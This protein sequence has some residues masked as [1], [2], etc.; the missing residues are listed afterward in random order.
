[1]AAP[2][3]YADADPQ[4]LILDSGAVLALAR[5]EPRA[6]AVLE[7]AWEAGIVVSMPA[8]VVAE[9]IR[10]TPRD[11]PVNQV[12]KTVAEVDVVDERRGRIA[13]ALLRA[14]R[15]SSTVD[16]LV[17]SMGVG[18]SCVIMTGDPDDLTA[19]AADHPEIVIQPV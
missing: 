9:T 16:A 17:V 18:Q 12:I 4:R 7:S 2:R 1:M 3:R 5:R 15:S 14:A 10:G 13:G 19:L 11:A 6:R 8:V